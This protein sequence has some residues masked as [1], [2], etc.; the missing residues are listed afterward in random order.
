MAIY[1]TNEF[2]GGLKVYT[3]LDSAMQEAAQT[4][5]ANQLNSIGDSS[6]DSAMAAIQTARNFGQRTRQPLRSAKNGWQ[7]GKFRVWRG[8]RGWVISRLGKGEK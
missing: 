8:F 1:S 7:G 3:T 4:A 2:K 5:V 6:L